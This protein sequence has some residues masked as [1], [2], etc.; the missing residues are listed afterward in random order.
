MNV[1]MFLACVFA[2]VSSLAAANDFILKCDFASRVREVNAKAVGEMSGVLPVGCSENF[3]GWKNAR[4]RARRMKEDGVEFVRFETATESAGQ[5]AFMNLNVEFP[6]CYIFRVRSRQLTAPSLSFSI[7]ENGEPY[8]G[9]WTDSV[10]SPEWCDREFIIRLPDN[11]CISIYSVAYHIIRD[12]VTNSFYIGEDVC[13]AFK[14]I[15]PVCNK[16]NVCWSKILNLM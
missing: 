7:R 5:F 14:P 3:A 13:K 10:M 11:F 8:R 4:V 1:K 12:R 16:K 2:A 15:I 9:F 6:G